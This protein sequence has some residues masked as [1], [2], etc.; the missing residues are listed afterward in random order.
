MR[1]AVGA[2]LSTLVSLAAAAADLDTPLA[3]GQHPA[4]AV[5]A[6]LPQP[7]ASRGIFHC[8]PCHDYGL[9]WDSLRKVRKAHVPFGGLRPTYVSG[10]PWGG[11]GPTCLSRRVTSRPVLVRKG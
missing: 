5:R 2:I 9:P 1:I 6:R 4:A 10:L 11:L 7:V 8:V 3:P